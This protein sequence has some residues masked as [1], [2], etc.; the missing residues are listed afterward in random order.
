[1]EWGKGKMLIKKDPFKGL[2]SI[3]L[4]RKGISFK[5]T[6]EISQL[7]GLYLFT[8][9]SRPAEEDITMIKDLGLRVKQ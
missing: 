3:L 8:T 2:E 9:C 7:D 6:L 5:R 4:T 1:M